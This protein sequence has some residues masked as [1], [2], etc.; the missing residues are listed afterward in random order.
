MVVYGHTPIPDLTWLN[1][2]INIDTGC[3]FGGSLTAL[4]YPEMELVA[5]LAE[6]HRSPGSPSYQTRSDITGLPDLRRHRSRV[7]YT[8]EAH[9]VNG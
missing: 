2:T 7:L 4:R 1:K 8:A 3:V 6:R 5:T 9:I